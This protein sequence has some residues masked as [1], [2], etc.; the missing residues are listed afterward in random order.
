MNSSERDATY[1]EIL[2]FVHGFG[3]QLALPGMQMAIESAMDAAI[4]NDYYNPLFDLPE[5]DYDEEYLAMGMECYFGLWS[6]DP[7]GDG[8][9]GDHEYAFITREEM[10]EGDSALFAI[11][12]GF[13][14]DTWEY[15][16][17][18][19]ETFNTDFYIHYQ[20]NLDYTHRSQYLKDIVL[21]GEG[22][23]SVFGNQH[24]NSFQGNSGDN[25]FQGFLGDDVIWGEEGLDRAIF[26]GNREEYVIIPSYATDDSS[27]Q[28]IDIS[29]D[30]DG[31]DHLFSVEEIE[32][33]GV[34]YTLSELLGVS[35]SQLPEEFSLYM[36]YPN[37]FNPTTQ[38]K[39]DVAE[40]GPVQLMVYDINGRLVTTLKDATLEPGNYVIDWDARDGKGHMISTGIY[41]I[42]FTAASYRN[43]K[44]VLFLK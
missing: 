27:Y 41:F 21:A 28:V 19:P 39:V 1:E 29:P 24:L 18:L 17:F 11:I 44:K 38:I 5:E 4:E 40:S 30:R 3:I 22:P 10:A 6:H 2:H 42:Q 25:H 32:F 9:C 37:P 20:T 26:E 33:N 43:T 16:A 23:V 36:P 35:Q 8:Y 7:S 14:G 12:K 34:V 13:V 15:T 31:T